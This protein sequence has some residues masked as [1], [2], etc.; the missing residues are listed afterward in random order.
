MIVDDIES[1]LTEVRKKNDNN[2]LKYNELVAK[3]PYVT[4][5]EEL[6]KIRE[7]LEKI[8]EENKDFYDY[9]ISLLKSNSDLN[10]I[11]LLYKEYNNAK[12]KEE[13]LEKTLNDK[14]MELDKIQND[15]KGKDYDVMTFDKE[16]KALKDMGN[17]LSDLEKT[18]SMNLD[19][20][21]SKITRE[22][23]KRLSFGMKALIALGSFFSFKSDKNILSS[24]F[25]SYLSYKLIEELFSSRKNDYIDLCNE[26]IDVLEGYQDDALNI[27]KDL[28]VNLDNIEDLESGLRSKYKDYLDE[29]EFKNLFEL[30]SNIKDS[31]NRSLNDLDKTK[32]DINRNIDSGKAKVKQLEV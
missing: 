16:V 7:F 30:I 21:F 22:E 8:K 23:D 17:I 5:Q 18:T 1:Y 9:I 4:S 3:C 11:F 25:A 13:V 15:I 20:L 19:N 32:D 10:S 6:N 2:S 24:L 29:K 27:E 31:I 12:N 28:I 26:Y 14:E